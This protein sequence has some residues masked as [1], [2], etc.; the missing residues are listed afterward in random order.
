MSPI[1]SRKRVPAPAT[2]NRPRFVCLASVKAPFSWPNSSD[3]SSASG[4][5]AQ[6]TATKGSSAVAPV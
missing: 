6:F 4:I 1:S 3:S 2:S 5:A